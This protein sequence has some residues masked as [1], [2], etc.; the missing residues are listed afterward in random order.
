M[1]EIR[2]MVIPAGL[3]DEGFTLSFKFRRVLPGLQAL[4]EVSGDIG[5][6]REDESID[7]L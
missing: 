7:I 4:N 2:S 6:I 5:K 3:L 1:T